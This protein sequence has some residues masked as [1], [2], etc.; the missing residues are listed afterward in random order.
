MKISKISFPKLKVNPNNWGHNISYIFIGVSLLLLI[1][2]SIPSD[3][4]NI[5]S[6]G[7]S[8]LVYFEEQTSSE[9]SEGRVLAEGEGKFACWNKDM[10]KELMQGVKKRGYPPKMVHYNEP[11]EI[12]LQ[13]CELE[14]SDES[15]YVGDG[16]HRIYRKCDPDRKQYT[17]QLMITAEF[18]NEEK[19]LFGFPDVEHHGL[20]SHVKRLGDNADNKNT[21]GT[22]LNPTE[23]L[24]SFLA[25]LTG[26]ESLTTANEFRGVVILY[27]S[28]GEEFQYSLP[29]LGSQIACMNLITMLDTSN[30]YSTVIHKHYPQFFQF[31]LKPEVQDIVNKIS[32]AGLEGAIESTDTDWFQSALEVF[33][34]LG[35][36]LTTMEENIKNFLEELFVSFSS[37]DK[38]L[39]GSNSTY[40][41]EYLAHEP[42]VSYETRSNEDA[43]CKPGN[44]GLNPTYDGPPINHIN[45]IANEESEAERGWEQIILARWLPFNVENYCANNGEPGVRVRKPTPPPSTEFVGVAPELPYFCDC[46]KVEFQCRLHEI[47]ENGIP[48]AK[49][50]ENCDEFELGDNQF[51]NGTKKI[52]K[53]WKIKDEFPYQDM[54]GSDGDFEEIYMNTKY[55]KIPEKIGV[56]GAMSGLG[57]VYQ[58]LQVRA[59]MLNH[60][61]VAPQNG[62]RVGVTVRYYD[63]FAE[64]MTDGFGFPVEDKIIPHSEF[65]KREGRI[66]FVER[67]DL[68]MKGEYYAQFI[69]PF[70]I[71]PYMRALQYNYKNKIDAQ[72]FDFKRNPLIQQSFDPYLIEEKSKI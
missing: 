36:L 26:N 13:S 9:I 38:R 46:I 54:P 30:Y 66:I 62:T 1:N 21:Y 32:K 35:D 24:C 68:F 70:D 5:E 65:D 43:F 6:V 49:G 20:T 45:L 25:R 67:R 7:P 17:G 16:W 33:T 37:D 42:I 23:P 3:S 59:K 69:L 11:K 55:P 72:D 22:T 63:P 29:A 47:G 60:D 15:G 51:F 39:F 12:E 57:R 50:W 71:A 40:K 61:L 44:S 41:R 2:E 56:P 14:Y 64:V 18:Y 10:K 28:N 52:C 19:G 48:V 27:S 58:Y 34:I 8:A 4:K 31:G 53:Q